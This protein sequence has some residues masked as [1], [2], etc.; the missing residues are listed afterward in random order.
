MKV[1]KPNKYIIRI[2][3]TFFIL[4]LLLVITFSDFALDLFIT[5][6]MLWLYINQ[7]K[8]YIVLVALTALF[9]FF[10]RGPVK[11]Q[12][13]YAELLEIARKNQVLIMANI[14]NEYFF[15][16]H[17]PKKP[18]DYISIGVED[19][20]GYT[21]EQFI[22]NFREYGFGNLFDGVFD[23]IATHIGNDLPYPTYQH[24]V[25]DKS[26]KEIVIEVKITPIFNN[27]TIIAIE[28]AVKDISQLSYV[29]NKLIEKEQL[30][31][32]LFEANNEAVVIM[33]GD[34]FIDCNK[35]VPEMFG[36]SIEDIIMHTPYSY[37]FSPPTQPDGRNSRD[38]ALEKIRIALS[39]TQQEFNWQHIRNNGDPFM[40]KVNLIKFNQGNELF[41]F[42]L[43]RDI[44]KDY[45]L[46]KQLEQQRASIDSFFSNTPLGIALF[47]TGKKIYEYNKSFSTIL[48]LKDEYIK[49]NN[50]INRIIKYNNSDEFYNHVDQCLAGEK[51]TCQIDFNNADGKKIILSMVLIPVFTTNNEVSGGIVLFEE[52]TDKIELIQTSIKF[53]EGT[54]EIIEHSREILYKLDV[55]T[56][57]YEYISPALKEVL[58]YEPEEFYQMTSESIKQLLHPED[59]DKSDHIIAKLIKTSDGRNVLNTIDYR[60]KH[61][62]GHYCWVS[63]K[64]TIKIDEKGKP[65]YIYG[66]VHN[67]SKLKEAEALI[68]SYS[69]NN[70]TKSD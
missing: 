42:G 64:Y 63:D 17:Y 67:I 57:Q 41:L 54:K 7:I 16:R 28:G 26:G 29:E 43:L 14:K 70:S 10:I 62:D 46:T 27:N 5:N 38:K 11:N 48:N 68:R 37:R 15:F 45:R 23:E 35:L 9:F 44:D 66:N 53:R 21:R 34:K 32:T 20:L 69:G 55:Q 49:E 25:K 22:K 52:I 12:G 8:L 47:N 60:I 3:S 4:G 18:F 1:I 58:G 59:L 61:K 50:D 40:V 36:C 65:I 39:G 19:M 2:V 33:K 30:Y 51:I 6:T 13:K 31:R 56:G 24:T